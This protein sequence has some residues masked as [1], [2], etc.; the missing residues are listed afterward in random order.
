MSLPGDMLVFEAPTVV[1]WDNS[2]KFWKLEEVEDYQYNEEERTIAFKTRKFGQF[3]LIQDLYI[4]MPFQSYEIIPLGMNHCSINISAAYIDITIEVKDNKC[5]LSPIESCTQL[6]GLYSKWM[7]PHQLIEVLRPSGV[8]I[9]PQPD[10]EKYVRVIEKD[11]AVIHTIYRDMAMSASAF[12]FTW[13]KWNNIE[14]GGCDKQNVITQSTEWLGGKDEKPSEDVYS[15]YM[16]SARIVY[17][18]KMDEFSSDFSTDIADGIEMHPNLFHMLLDG[19]TE[20]ARQRC[21]DTSF[22]FIDTVKQLLEA[23]NVFVYS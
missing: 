2:V 5:C 17:Q 4:N 10:G 13:S 8:N 15:L 1:K 7:T 14:S 16:A 21:K 18:L 6:S 20:K 12:A 3:S 19:C 23:T 22:I 11:S 9:F